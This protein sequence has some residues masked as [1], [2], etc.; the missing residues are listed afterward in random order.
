MRGGQLS[1]TDDQNR[2]YGNQLRLVGNSGLDADAVLGVLQ[3]LGHVQQRQGNVDGYGQRLD[4]LDRRDADAAEE[5]RRQRVRDQEA[6]ARG[7]R[8]HADAEAEAA[9]RSRSASGAAPLEGLDGALSAGADAMNAQGEL[10]TAAVAAMGAFNATATALAGTAAAQAGQ[11]AALRQGQV[12][13][14]QQIANINRTS[15]C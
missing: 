4:A 12:G 10:S 14:Q 2:R 8:R 11:I 5:Q 15:I 3:L 7:A 6:A 1:V 13:L 9:R